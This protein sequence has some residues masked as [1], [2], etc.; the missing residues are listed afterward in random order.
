MFVMLVSCDRKDEKCN[1]YNEKR[2]RDKQVKSQIEISGQPFS[3]EP[4]WPKNEP[5]SEP[6]ARRAAPHSDHLLSRLHM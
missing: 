4:D 6:E 1:A 2:H 3:P 5:N